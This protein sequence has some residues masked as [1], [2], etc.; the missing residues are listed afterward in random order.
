MAK[1]YYLVHHGILGQK[2]GVR[3][4]QNPDGSYTEE[5][6]RRRRED[7]DYVSIGNKQISKSTLKKVAIGAAAVGTVAAATLYVKSHPE[8]IGKIIAKA[9]PKVVSGVSKTTVNKGKDIVNQV[10]KTAA[11]QAVK[12]AIDGMKEAPYKVAKAVVGGAAI[13]AANKLVENTIG[14]EQNAK[15]KQAYNAYNKKNKIGSLPKDDE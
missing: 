4:F 7:S 13:L 5:G 9:G 8:V 2:W 1:D 10:L 15:Y 11:E 6:K 3:R 12:G 14:K